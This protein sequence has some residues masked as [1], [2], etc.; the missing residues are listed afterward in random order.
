MLE[1]LAGLILGA[2]AVWF[3]ER[4][5]DRREA[6]LMNLIG[7]LQIQVQTLQGEVQRLKEPPI[8]AEEM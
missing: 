8:P 4:Y 6:Q 1:M 7:Q 2:A 3:I 5:H